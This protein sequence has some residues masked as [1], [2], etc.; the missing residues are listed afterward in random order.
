MK[1]LLLL[2]FIVAIAA[3][4]DTQK[5]KLLKIVSII[6]HGART[7]LKVLYFLYWS[8][9]MLRNIGMELKKAD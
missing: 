6:R 1:K 4:A 2:L 7:P 3:Q 5:R 9:Y 8:P